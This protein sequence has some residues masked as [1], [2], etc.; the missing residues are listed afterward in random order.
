MEN[1]SSAAKGYIR[2]VCEH[3]ATHRLPVHEGAV[4][5]PQVD[6]DD[7][8]VLHAQLSVV[9][10]DTG[11]NHAQ[12][13]VRAAAEQGH[14]RLKLIGAARFHAGPRLRSSH[15]KPGSAGELA[16]ATPRQVADRLPDF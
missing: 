16:T 1:Q 10:R 2:A 8:A 3:D 15:H 9:P 12:V 6:E 14:G 7:L 5:G 11:V 13:A 4:G